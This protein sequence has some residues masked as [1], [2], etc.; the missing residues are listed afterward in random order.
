MRNFRV[1][2]SSYLVYSEKKK[3]SEHKSQCS[4]NSK[5]NAM[6]TQIPLSIPMCVRLSR[7]ENMLEF[8]TGKVHL[9]EFCLTISVTT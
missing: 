7:R 9:C 8:M 5:V 3:K 4:K 6:H 1:Q 2:N